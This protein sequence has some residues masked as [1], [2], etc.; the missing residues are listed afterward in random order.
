MFLLPSNFLATSNT[1]NSKV[2]VL[3]YVAKIT[4]FV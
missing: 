3:K 1:V 2:L 4:Y